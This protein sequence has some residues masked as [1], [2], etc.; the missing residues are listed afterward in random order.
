MS[1]SNYTSK[2][3]LDYMFGKT[4]AFDSQPAIYVALSTADPGDD[5]ASLS[6]P[7]GNGYARVAT[8]AGDWNAGTLANPSVIDNAN[9]VT[10]PEVVTAPWGT[11]SHFALYDAASNGN[12]LGS[13][14]LDTQKSPTVGDTPRFQP[15]SLETSLT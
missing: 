14:A 4:S 12:C 8:V 11:I 15:G 6:E 2:A 3:L 5:G 10:F 7:S 13:E 9:A 1:F